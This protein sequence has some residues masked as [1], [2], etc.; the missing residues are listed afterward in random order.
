M[1]HREFELLLAE[2]CAPTLLSHKCA[3][4][5]TLSRRT[6]PDLSFLSDYSRTFL[7]HGISCRIICSCDKR[8]LLLLYRREQLSMQLSKPGARRILSKLG[9]PA[10]ADPEALLSR[11]EG[12]FLHSCG[13]F[14]H[15][16]GLF[17]GYPA[18]DVADFIRFGGRGE[19]LCGYWKVYHDPESAKRKFTLYDRCRRYLC[20]SLQNGIPISTL[21]F[22]A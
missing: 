22:A 20:C 15:E 11:L 8:A 4:L 17:L 10:D 7:P 14:P 9:Y 21:L 12:R 3:S 6:F 1:P 2:H 19:R 13:E 18:E 5:V 16:I